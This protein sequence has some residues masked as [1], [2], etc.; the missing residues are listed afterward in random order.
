LY[1]NKEFR[2]GAIMT[3]TATSRNVAGTYGEY[4]SGRGNGLVILA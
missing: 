2:Q 1:L 4:E 3:S